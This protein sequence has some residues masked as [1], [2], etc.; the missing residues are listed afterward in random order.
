MTD[1]TNPQLAVWLAFS[2]RP[3]LRKKMMSASPSPQD[4]KALKAAGIDSAAKG[5][6]AM[7]DALKPRAAAME[8]VNGVFHSTIHDMMENDYA[9]PDCPSDAQLDGISNGGGQ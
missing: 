7:M 4:V 9:P 6:R 5:T 2:T 8:Q 3:D 1:V